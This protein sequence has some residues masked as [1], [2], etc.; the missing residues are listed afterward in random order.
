MSSR[1]PKSPKPQVVKPQRERFIEKARE[2]G[3]DESGK[4]FERA[5]KKI[6]PP[7]KPKTGGDQ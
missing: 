6:V 4:T 5:F 7:K 3:S 2:I 1:R